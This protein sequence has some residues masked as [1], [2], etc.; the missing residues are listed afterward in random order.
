MVNYIDALVIFTCES[1]NLE[2]GQLYP[3][4]CNG[5]LLK[6]F[7]LENLLRGDC[8]KALQ[9]RPRRYCGCDMLMRKLQ[10]FTI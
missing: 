1:H 6:G 3:Y 10:K 8:I 5:A 9:L 4:S 7:K 2:L